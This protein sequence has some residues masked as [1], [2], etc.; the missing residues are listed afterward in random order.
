MISH[1]VEIPEP[2]LCEFKTISPLQFDKF[3]TAQDFLNSDKHYYRSYYAQVQTYLFLLSEDKQEFYDYG[4]VVLLDKNA[5]DFKFILFETD[6]DFIETEILQKCKY[7]ND[8]IKNNIIPDCIEYD[9]DVCNE[10]AFGHICDVNKSY[11]GSEIIFN[12]EIADALRE[13]KS[14]KPAIKRDKELKDYIDNFFKKLHEQ[15]GNNHFLLDEFEA[16]ITHINRK[17]YSVAE[18][19]YDKIDYKEVKK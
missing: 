18:T 5:G 16:K 4:Y 6:Y 11:T 2:V 14:L 10:C 9:E 8:C 1:P 7:I 3:N 15:T 17:A 13:R 19:Q 12:A